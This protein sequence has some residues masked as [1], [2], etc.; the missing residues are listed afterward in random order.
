MQ[1][2]EFLSDKGVYYLCTVATQGEEEEVEAL[3]H[4][5]F[6]VRTYEED[7]TVPADEVV[8]SVKKEDKGKKGGKKK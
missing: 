1:A 2:N 4:D 7:L 3:T 5:G 8:F 6:P